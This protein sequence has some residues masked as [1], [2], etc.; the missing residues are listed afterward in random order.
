MILT[1]TN[2]WI[3]YKII[4]KGYNSLPL[5]DY[6]GD[7]GKIMDVIDHMVKDNLV[8]IKNDVIYPK[9]LAFSSYLETIA[10]F[11]EPYKYDKYG[12]KLER[13][14]SEPDKF[15]SPFDKSDSIID[16]EDGSIQSDTIYSL[17]RNL[18]RKDGISIEDSH[19]G[20]ISYYPVLERNYLIEITRDLKVIATAPGKS[21]VRNTEDV[22]KKEG[23]I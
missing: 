14:E 21:A 12:N 18:I 3:I 16:P 9:L 7:D 10:Y 6:I 17:L 8:I 1:K 22:L 20:A 13:F 4:G 15:D 11:N 2:F 5:M 19:W 23:I